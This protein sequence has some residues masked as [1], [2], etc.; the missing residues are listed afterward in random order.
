MNRNLAI[1]NF[2]SVLLVIIVNYFSQALRLND[3]TIGGVSDEY[4]NLF[5]PQ[6]YAFSI[7]GLIFLSL[8]LYCG[9]QIYSAFFNNKDSEFI[10][11]T[12]PW[13]AIANFANACWVIV[14]LYEL[15][16][17]SVILMFVILFSLLKIIL[18]TNMER[19]DAPFKIIAFTWWP[20]CL[21]AG[22]ITVA[23]ITN[24]AAFLVKIG[25]RG[26]IL[27]EK[28]WTII[29]II[30]AVAINALIIYKRN[31]RE[32]AAVGAWALIAIY[33]RHIDRF[34]G[35]AYIALAGAILLLVYIFYHGYKYRKTN[36]MFKLINGKENSEAY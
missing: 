14:W 17:I 9:F 10:T 7:W 24:V 19:W 3:N 20:I 32:F 21:Y 11:K 5:T 26:Y 34:P 25:W 16:G 18:N 33:L 29:M 23:T 35:L 31:M 6:D 28:Q 36:P 12:G 15:T 13:F 30:V 4:R 1:M 27:D 8:L 22:W 2:L